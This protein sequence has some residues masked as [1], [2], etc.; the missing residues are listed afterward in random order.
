M[1]RLD[2]VR[3]AL[4]EVMNAP[5]SYQAALRRDELDDLLTDG[6]LLCLLDVVAAAHR[7]AEGYPS[8]KK[9]NHAPG[10]CPECDIVRAVRALDAP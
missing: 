8:F 6:V 2:A 1:T 7:L 5:N 3:A 9:I 10:T 4:Q